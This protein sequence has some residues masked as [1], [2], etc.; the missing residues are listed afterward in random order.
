MVVRIQHDT[1]CTIR[2]TVNP[3]SEPR[4]WLDIQPTGQPLDPATGSSLPQGYFSTFLSIMQPLH[5][6]YEC[7]AESYVS[8]TT[9]LAPGATL[10]AHVLSLNVRPTGPPLG[11]ST[12]QGSE[13]CF[14]SAAPVPRIDEASASA[15][16]S[17]AHLEAQSCRAAR[18]PQT[19]L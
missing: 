4:A 14:G 8:S 5:H 2:D 13:A 9:H 12:P 15:R 11:G 1:S 7:R 6:S 16:P 10:S 18:C 19:R 3:R 17:H